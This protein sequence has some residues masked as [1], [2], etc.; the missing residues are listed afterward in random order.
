M[1]TLCIDRVSGLFHCFRCLKS[2]NWYQFKQSVTAALYGQTLFPDDAPPQGS[3]HDGPLRSQ[4]GR[5]EHDWLQ[6]TE[7]TT[8]HSQYDVLEMKKR[9]DNLHH[10]LFPETLKYLTDTSSASSR[11]LNEETLRLFK[12]GLGQ[13]SFYDQESGGWATLDVVYFPMF[14]PVMDSKS[15]ERLTTL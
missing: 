10:N 3:S 8:S 5:P 6:R 1:Y 14:H 15:R 4:P 13:E 7:E 11:H 12:V 2:G 9:L